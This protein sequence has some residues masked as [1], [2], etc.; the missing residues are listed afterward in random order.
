VLE[1]SDE[2]LPAPI[3]PDETWAATEHA[4]HAC[5]PKFDDSAAP[6]DA[7]HAYAVLR[8]MTTQGG[9]MVAAATLGL[10]ERAKAGRNYD[11]R[12]VWLRDQCY[13]GLAVS[14]TEP[15]PL[16]RDAVAFTTARVLEHGD[17]IAPRLPAG[18]LG[19]ARRVR[20]AAAR[21]SRRI[22]RRHGKLGHQPVP[23]GRSR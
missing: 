3:D 23:T 20:P 6:R 21:V 15:H 11:Y 17:K 9:G 13:A 14:V 10:P 8:G 7:R 2:R 22:R 19:T 16:L 18:R 1:I 4:W 12:Y 5:V